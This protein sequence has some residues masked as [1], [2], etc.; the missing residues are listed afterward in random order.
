MA[1]K[2]ALDNAGLLDSEF[3]DDS[4]L[5]SEDRAYKDAARADK[6]KA[7]GKEIIEGHDNESSGESEP[8]DG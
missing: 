5:D 3:E 7:E 4:D 6:K 1:E 8:E 2:E